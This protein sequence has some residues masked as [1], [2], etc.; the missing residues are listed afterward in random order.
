MYYF[1]DSFYAILIREHKHLL[2]QGKL[3]VKQQ[4]HLL[5]GKMLTKLYRKRSMML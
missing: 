5:K 4:D 2:D 3:E 1:V